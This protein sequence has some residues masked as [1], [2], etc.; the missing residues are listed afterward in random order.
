MKKLVFLFA[1]LFITVIAVQNVNAQYNESAE[2]QVSAVI[3]TPI[4]I[5]KE[6]DLAFGNIIA[7]GIAGTVTVNTNDV[8]T[9][10]AGATFPTIAGTVSSAEFKVTGFAGSVYSITLPTDN[11]I[12]LEGTGVDM[13]LTGFTHNA[14]ELL[15]ESGEETFKV[16]A[17]LNVN[18]DQAAGEYTSNFDVIVNYN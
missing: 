6:A 9:Q 3:I 8:R 11:S 17:T 16:G 5:V 1:S 10:T 4:D 18:A 13:N 12:K 15:N 7:S 14:E 2:A